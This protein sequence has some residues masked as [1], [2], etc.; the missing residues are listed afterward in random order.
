MIVFPFCEQLVEDMSLYIMLTTV[1]SIS[2]GRSCDRQTN[3]L[4]YSYS[5]DDVTGGVDSALRGFFLW[6]G[7]RRLR[8]PSHQRTVANFWKWL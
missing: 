4:P 2:Y 7:I 5:E 6:G 8:S 1:S 3:R